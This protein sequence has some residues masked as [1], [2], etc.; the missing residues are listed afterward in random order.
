[1][2]RRSF[3]KKSA[4]LAGL[5]ALNPIKVCQAIGKKKP[6]YDRSLKIGKLDDIV[7]GESYSCVST[8]HIQDN[9]WY[10]L[11]QGDLWS[12][13]LS[14]KEASELLEKYGRAYKINTGY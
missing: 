5:L 13:P 4:L 1:M 8:F 7:D 2:N 12:K 10:V 6:N 14:S 3:F 11:Q 9:S